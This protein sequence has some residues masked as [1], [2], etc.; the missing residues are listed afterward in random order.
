MARPTRK[1]TVSLSDNQHPVVTFEGDYIN[2]RELDLCMRALKKKQREIIREYRRKEIIAKYELEKKGQVTDDTRG[3]ESTESGRNEAEGTR[4]GAG[5]T[6]PAKTPDA[7]SAGGS[8]STSANR[9]GGLAGKVPGAPGTA[10]QSGEQA[11]SDA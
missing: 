7:G 10:S 6:E 4:E 11:K 3:T 8:I 9:V 2:K 5:G 1:F